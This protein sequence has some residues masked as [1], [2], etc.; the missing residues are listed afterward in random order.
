MFQ[1]RNKFFN[2]QLYSIVI[3][4]SL[5]KFR[6]IYK[7]IVMLTVIDAIYRT[8]SCVYTYRAKDSFCRANIYI[9]GTKTTTYART[10]VLY[11]RTFIKK[12]SKLDQNRSHVGFDNPLFFRDS[13]LLIVD[14]K[15]YSLI[16]TV[17]IF[18]SWT[19]KTRPPLKTAALYS[20]SSL[21]ISNSVRLNPSL[22]ALTEFYRSCFQSWRLRT[23]CGR[24]DSPF[25]SSVNLFLIWP[26][27]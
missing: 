17:F 10:Y 4:S 20:S 22:F 23:F 21:L 9:F 11:S 3:Y 8:R 25:P 5:L 24:S 1:C 12:L 19:L 2:E 6:H 14:L 16:G 13:R 27:S 18:L 26:K 15:I 7:Q